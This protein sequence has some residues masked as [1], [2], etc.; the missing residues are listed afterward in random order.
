MAAARDIA[1][2]HGGQVQFLA[3]KVDGLLERDA[4]FIGAGED[5]YPP[6]T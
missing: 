1:P 4:E 3:K 5:G 6:R 2:C